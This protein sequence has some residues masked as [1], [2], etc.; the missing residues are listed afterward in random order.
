M[1]VHLQVTMCP[2]SRGCA[3]SFAG[4]PIA[5]LEDVRLRGPTFVRLPSRACYVK[6]AVVLAVAQMA[7]VYAAGGGG[8]E[9]LLVPYDVLVNNV[10]E[11]EVRTL[12]HLPYRFV[13]LAL[14]QHLTPQAAWTVLGGA[15]SSKG[16]HVETQ[17]APLLSFLRTEEV[18]GSVIPF[19]AADLEVVAPDKSLKA[20]LME[21]LR[22]DIGKSKF[23]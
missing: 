8:A 18:Q 3:S 14:D 20:Q 21:I 16:E 10:E 12:V 4:V 22:R 9:R 11:V 17:C 7:P 13:P 1:R 19:A 23:C 15:I 2:R 6:K 5:Q